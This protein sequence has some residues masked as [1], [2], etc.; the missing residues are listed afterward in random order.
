MSCLLDA[1]IR[2][3]IRWPFEERGSALYRRVPAGSWNLDQE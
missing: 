1:G 2:T 3:A